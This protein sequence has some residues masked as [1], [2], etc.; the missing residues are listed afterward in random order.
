M[1]A[2]QK[3][4]GDRDVILPGGERT[5]YDYIPY[6]GEEMIERLVKL[7][8]ELHGITV[9]QVNSALV[10]GGVAE[11][12]QSLIPIQRSM[13]L[14][15]QW[16]V[17]TGGH[18]FFR[19]T[20]SLHNFLQGKETALDIMGAKTYW[21]TNAVNARLIDGTADVV[22]IH[23]PQPAGLIALVGPEIRARQK[24]VWRC[25]IQLAREI[26]Q[27]TDY[28]RSLI[29]L[30]D[31]AIFSSA[32]SLPQWNITSYISLPYIDPLAEKNR[33]LTDEQ[34]QGIRAEYGIDDAEKKPIIL[35]VSRF[36]PFKGHAYAIEA[37]ELVRRERPCQ[38]VLVGGTAADDPENQEIFEELQDRVAGR[39]DIHLLNLPPDSHLVIN[40]L[41]RAASIILQPSIREGFGLTVS[42]GMWKGKPVIGGDVGGIPA[43]IADGYNGF[44]VTPGP[45]GVDEMALR[46]SYLLRNPLLAREMGR[47]GQATVKERFLITRGIW[48]E[49][50]LV[51]NLV[52]Q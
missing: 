26:H 38:L 34:V 20:K 6:A 50:T 24:W 19:F 25:H 29:E 13:G 1:T 42:E 21:E 52:T 15:V 48:D 11:M 44:L 30:Y 17:I 18:E 46:I 45:D 2:V 10:G 39:P 22:L 35:L 32:R 5:I 8:E 16:N 51:K 3:G 9:Q 43:Q 23:D 27:V 14:D 7:S 37:F 28:L 40:A 41:Q 33:E 49:L 47:R 4:A 36:D 12:L 31:A